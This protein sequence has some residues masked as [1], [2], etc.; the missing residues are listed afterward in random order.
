[1]AKPFNRTIICPVV[2]G[3]DT[4]LSLLAR[5]FEEVAG[6]QGQTLLLA[7]EAGI[8]KSRLV[9]EAKWIALRGGWRIVE[10]HCFETDRILPYAPLL[11]L[12]RTLLV[13]LR[14]EEIEALLGPEARDL[15]KILPEL[16]RKLP[17]IT[18]APPLDPAQ[19]RRLAIQALTAV[20]LRLAGNGPALVVVE[21]LHW[22]DDTSLD[23]L[24][25]L[26]RDIRH[27]PILLLLTYRDDEI[28][29][30]LSHAL[31]TFD[32][33]RLADELPLRRLNVA[34]VGTMLH[35]IFAGVS[36]VRGETLD[37]LH[38]LTDGNPF[39]IEEILGTL[40][41]A[42]ESTE[43]SDLQ[44]RLALDALEEPQIPRSVQDA[45]QRRVERLT[46]EVR[47][48]LE[49]AAVAGRRFDFSLLQLLTGYDETELLGLVK[50]LIAAQLLVE[51]VEDRF[52][53]RHAL[54]REAVYSQL[55]S[56][57]RRR[58]HQTIAK[59]LEE[60]N[61][62]AEELPLADLAYHFYA[63]GEW[64]PA[65]DYASRAGDQALALH[66]PRA[67]IEQFSRA[68]DAAKRLS[69]S[70]ASSLYRALGRA[71]ETLGD[72]ERARAEYEV[73]LAA[74]REAHDQ[75]E[76]WRVLLDLGLFWSGHDYERTAEYC[77][78]ALSLARTI[79]DPVILAHSLNRFGNWHTNV[80][81]PRDALA[82]HEEALAIFKTTDDRHALVETLDLL[83]IAAFI[84]GK[85]C[86]AAR[87]YREAFD[88][89][90]ELE[91]TP[92]F[93]TCLSTFSLCGSNYQTEGGATAPIVVDECIRLSERAIA[94]AEEAGLRL[95]EAITQQI[96][97]IVRTAQGRYDRAL[98]HMQ[99]GLAIAEEIGHRQWT[100][101]GQCEMGVIY[102][103]LLDARRARHYLERAR[104]GAEAMGSWQW[105]LTI[106]QQLAAACLLDRDLN[107]A[108]A[109]LDAAGLTGLPEQVG[110]ARECWIY[111]AELHLARGNAR[112]TLGIADQLIATDP[113]I[114]G[115]R[116]V[117]RVA[118][119]RG[120]ALMAL[121][122]LDEAE[123]SLRASVDGAVALGRP[124]LVW[125]AQVALGNVLR[126]QRRHSEADAS[127]AAARDVIRE[128]AATVPESALRETFITNALAQ[129]PRPRQPT[130]RR[131]AR[132]TGSVKS[133]D[134]RTV[135]RQRAD[136]RYPCQPRPQQARLQLPHASGDLGC[137]SGAAE[138][139]VSLSHANSSTRQQKDHQT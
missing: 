42:E 74:A 20:F 58:L 22:S 125:R 43:P 9:S 13:G 61:A 66:A 32:R 47:R 19:E 16:G 14:S 24:L 87:N 15:I 40:V 44:D 11:D 39:F 121:G 113:D 53:F 112:E 89:F 129:M 98:E 63:A 95:G 111:L 71:Y 21:D 57:E 122:R 132:R 10:G 97:G 83:G 46:P 54:T 85:P 81:R 79:G 135:D 124:G 34:D 88:I 78:Q 27:S 131:A 90:E 67:A 12:L 105:V 115:E 75:R 96:A 69:R 106:S 8:G 37:T 128:L 1:M 26:A 84:A 136:G 35:A 86:D 65:L 48:V 17:G 33:E 60:L 49:L 18:T 62:V 116:A 120:E 29:P 139:R 72:F 119:L 93:Y 30:E 82:Y 110:G 77:R 137:R 64:Q 101:S 31:A 91:A 130:P 138:R 3:R 55:L 51:E 73:A 59:A 117:P 109:V 50:E 4:Q 23:A 99:R 36:P 70:P 25:H 94:L 126:R 28:T 108:Q 68:L 114:T 2:I 133:N 107:A 102:L 7:G 38:A 45:V 100:V 127:Y 6:A 56:R 5:A 41:R 52:A 103:D 123:I 118:R 104:A 92:Q 134:R 80:G 76:E